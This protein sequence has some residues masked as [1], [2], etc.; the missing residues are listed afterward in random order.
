MHCGMETPM[1]LLT[2]LVRTRFTV[3]LKG[4]PSPRF[5]LPPWFSSPPI[6]N[7]KAGADYGLLSDLVGETNA[8]PEIILVPGN[9]RAR[10]FPARYLDGREGRCEI[11]R[12]GKI[13]VGALGDEEGQGLEVEIGLARRTVRRW[14][15]SS[16]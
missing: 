4:T 12:Q 9:Q 14:A 10:H 2:P 15:K 1:K 16:S 8:R 7:T 13:L 3:S 11:R 6:E 5:G